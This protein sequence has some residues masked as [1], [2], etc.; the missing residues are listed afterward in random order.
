MG[1]QANGG[2]SGSAGTDADALKTQC[3]PPD[4]GHYMPHWSPPQP[5]PGTCTTAQIQTQYELCQDRDTYDRD[6]CR[7]FNA[8][9]E[10][11]ACIDCLFSAVGA[12]DSHA[13]LVFPT[14]YPVANV[15][16]CIALLDGDTSDTSCGALAQAAEVCQY[17]GCLTT[18]N[19]STNTAWVHCLEQAENGV[20]ADFFNA[21]ACSE[22]PKYAQCHW[23]DW[24]EFFSQYG[25]LFCGSGPPSNNPGAAGAAP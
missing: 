1:G 7:A 15:G 5:T 25:D 24:H 8:A 18:C 2:S 23:G 3:D 12:A 17:R 19:R 16:G 6:Q 20:C 9:A 11:A 13:L 4:P 22:L 14:G 10:N 21:A